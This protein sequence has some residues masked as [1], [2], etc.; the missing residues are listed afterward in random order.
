ML[1][2]DRVSSKTVPVMVEYKA[3]TASED[4]MADTPIRDPQQIRVRGPEEVVSKI[5]DAF[6]PI[7]RESLASTFEDDLEFVLRDEN[8]EEFDEKRL[9]GVTFSAEM[10]RVTIPI[11]QKKDISLSASCMHGAGSTDINTKITVEPPFI[12]LAGDPDAMK[13]LN[14]IILTTI[15]TVRLRELTT[16]ESY[17]I[18]YENYYEI[19][20]GVKEATVTIE[21]LG[22]TTKYSRTENLQVSN[23]PVGFTYKIIN[24][25][26]VVL[27][28]GTEEDL[29]YIMEDDNGNDNRIR[30]V[31]DLTDREAGTHR[32]PAKVYID[33]TDANIGAVGEYT[34]TVILQ[35]DTK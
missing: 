13:E 18:F 4:L 30:I 20:S 10:V 11:K 12:T 35:R 24:E 22:L 16:I 8:G 3:G 15:D 34:L 23:V 21:L 2:V 6:V 27:I 7:P 9:E 17:P 28:R 25:S 26:V 1:S 29:N 19:L 5:K 33:G 32:I 14:T 31:A